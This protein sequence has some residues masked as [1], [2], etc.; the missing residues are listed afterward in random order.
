MAEPYLATAEAL[1][2][3]TNLPAT[4]PKLLLALDRAS[5][6]FRGEVGHPVT[7]VEDDIILLDGGGGELLMLPAVPVTAITEVKVAGTVVTD[8][9]ASLRAGILRRTPGLD[10]IWGWTAAWPDGLGNI[11][12]TYSHGVETVPGDIQD[13]VLEHAATLLLAPIG[14][15]QE[16]AG[17]QSITWGVASTTGVTQKWADVVARHTL[18]RGDRT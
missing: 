2:L 15:Q 10:P 7:L 3:V 14:V 17:S 1:A 9:V 4:S 8:W 18:I 12:V 11:Q 5:E 16:T 6:R 13:A